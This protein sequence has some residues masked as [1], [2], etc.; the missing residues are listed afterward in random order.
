MNIQD[1]VYVFSQTIIITFLVIMM[2]MLIEYFHVKTSG[3]LFDL[4]RK[5]SWTQVLI[6]ALIGLIPGCIG[7]FTIV[8]LYTHKVVGFGALLAALIAS[9]GDEALLM[10]SFIPLKATMIAGILFVIA[11][12]FCLSMYYFCLVT[13]YY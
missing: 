8:S 10:F 6:S 4:M 7:G 12:I 2:M 3:K 13:W 9:F 1:V 5:N 11:V